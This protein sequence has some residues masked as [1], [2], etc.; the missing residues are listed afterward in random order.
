MIIVKM[1]VSVLK[2][3]M[4]KG[5]VTLVYGAKDRE[6]NEAILLKELFS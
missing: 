5:I 2:E 6:H 1:Q 3:Q 4:Q